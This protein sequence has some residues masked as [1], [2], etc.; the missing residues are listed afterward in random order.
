MFLSKNIRTNT[1]TIKSHD[2]QEKPLAK[3][4]EKGERSESNEKEDKMDKGMNNKDFKYR[5][6]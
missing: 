2:I 5:N 1:N 6:E 4:G 3:L